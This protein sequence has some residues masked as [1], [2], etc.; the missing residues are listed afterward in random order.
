M[1]SIQPTMDAIPEPSTPRQVIPDMYVGISPSFSTHFL[2]SSNIAIPPLQD[3]SYYSPFMNASSPTLNL[4]PNHFPFGSPMS[5]ASP[6]PPQSRIP[7]VKDH[8]SLQLSA[9]RFNT[10]FSNENDGHTRLT[11]SSKAIK[12]NLQYFGTFGMPLEA[13]NT[14]SSLPCTPIRHNCPPLADETPMLSVTPMRLQYRLKQMGS[15]RAILLRS[16][17]KERK[18]AEKGR[19]LITCLKSTFHSHVAFHEAGRSRLS[20]T[21]PKQVLNTR[22]DGD[23]QIH[24]VASGELRVRVYENKYPVKR[25][26]PLLFQREGPPHYT[27]WKEEDVI[28]NT[29]STM[30]ALKEI[31]SDKMRTVRLGSDADA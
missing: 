6:L 25:E 5:P 23:Y 15:R 10:I 9:A 20:V 26:K 14:S 21:L 2:S 7:K 3:Y 24:T 4:F 17:E 28:V 22:C 12:K 18:V 11:R 13:A 19:N 27:V 8:R 29:E 16:P 1:A 31:S 30:I